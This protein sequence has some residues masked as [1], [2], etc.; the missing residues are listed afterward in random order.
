MKIL[1][2]AASQIHDNKNNS[3]LYQLLE[4]TIRSG[5]LALAQIAA[6]TPKKHEIEIIDENRYERIDVNKK[7]DLVG[8]SFITQNA[9]R[10]YKIA[11]EFRKKGIPVVLGG[12]HPSS[13]PKEAKEHADSVVVGEAELNW[14]KLLNDFENNNLKPFY[15]Q[16]DYV[17]PKLIP[18]AYRGL[19]K[20]IVLGGEVQATRGCPYRCDFCSIQNVEGTRFR[21]RPIEDVIKEIKQ[22]KSSSFFFADP[23][24]TIDVEYSKELFREM[25]G[26]KKQFNCD[27]NVNALSEDEEL[28]KLSKEAG[29]N[30]WW[31]G[32]ES[33]CKESLKS[34]GKKNK[35]QN[36]SKAI[37]KIRKHGLGVRGMFMFGFDHDTKNIFDSTQKAINKWNLD[38]AAF[39]ILTP[40]PGTPVFKKFDEEDR[41]LTYDWSKY[42]PWNVVFEPKNM[43]S[44]EL[45]EGTRKIA[46]NFFSL[47]NNIRRMID[48]NGFTYRSLMNKISLNFFADKYEFKQD[49]NF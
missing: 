36:Y 46:K 15:K 29:C 47:S 10:G 17:D 12:Y 26:L 27:G 38:M 34:V 41:I 18:P 21:K 6:V 16:E 11:D 49:L 45:Y 33:I 44:G 3:L 14:P 42:T 32:F 23:S 7:Y 35:V 19:E 20:G 37:N 31:I 5:S 43:T 24:L 4:K 13:M 9:V 22:M 30:S 28:I 40:F 8:I 25:K 1:I 2:S 48:S 39:F